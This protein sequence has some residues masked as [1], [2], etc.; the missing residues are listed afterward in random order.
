[1]LIKPQIR[2]DQAAA[3]VLAGTLAVA[4]TLSIRIILQ[5]EEKSEA[6]WKAHSTWSRSGHDQKWER[7]VH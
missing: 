7:G 1:M 4:R 3:A 2:F 5:N 6:G